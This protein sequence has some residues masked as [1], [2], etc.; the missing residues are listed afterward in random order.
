MSNF[1][2]LLYSGRE[3][4]GKGREGKRAKG[5]GVLG[6]THNT[7]KPKNEA[8]ETRDEVVAIRGTAIPG[9]AVPR[10]ATKYTGSTILQQDIKIF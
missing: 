10:A 4:K 9:I 5:Y 7:R 3:K 6:G 1:V 2:Q 8:D